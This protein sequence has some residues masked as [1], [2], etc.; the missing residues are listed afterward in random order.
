M[1]FNQRLLMFWS[2]QGRQSLGGGGLNNESSISKLQD[3]KISWGK[4]T[5]Y[6]Q[7]GLRVWGNLPN[8]KY[9]PLS[10]LIICQ[11]H[12][13]GGISLSMN[14]IPCLS[15]LCW[16][17]FYELYYIGMHNE[18]LRPKAHRL[19]KNVLL[20]FRWY[21]FQSTDIQ[22]DSCCPWWVAWGT[23]VVIGPENVWKL[24]FL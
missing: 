12:Y 5:P 2:D 20:G 11:S 6:P 22:G 23:F 9:T 7:T 3:L 14:L 18:V 17:S 8:S 10:L 4:I 13:E 21:A 24:R 15:N 16:I 1:V 19:D